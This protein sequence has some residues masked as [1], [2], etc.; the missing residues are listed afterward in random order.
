MNVSMITFHQQ[1]P[2]PRASIVNFYVSF[3]C[4][5]FGMSALQACNDYTMMWSELC[6]VHLHPPCLWFEQSCSTA[7]LL[8]G[9]NTFNVSVIRFCGQ[10]YQSVLQRSIQ[11]LWSEKHALPYSECS[12]TSLHKTIVGDHGFIQGM[13]CNNC[14]MYS[15]AN[16][17]CKWC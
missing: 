13:F 16:I 4:I 3:F 8:F 17:C 7:K 14:K 10:V 6:S 9:P 2:L 15:T 5:P 1:D 12:E 11:S